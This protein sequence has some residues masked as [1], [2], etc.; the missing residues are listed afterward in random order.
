MQNWVAVASANHVAIG[1]AQGF[2]QVNH[3][4]SGPLRRMQPK[5]VIAYYSPTLVYGERTPLQAFT[6]LG[7][8]AEGAPY[9]GQMPGGF[10]PYRRDVIWLPSHPA[11]IAPLLQQLECTAGKSNWGYPF[12][13]GLFKIT[14]ADMAL[15]AHAMG[16]VLPPQP[17]L[18]T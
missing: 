15:I 14:P 17:P 16:C 1:R 8:I 6:A 18:A 10:T 11:P 12:R 5:D 9:V 13:F 4:K 2:A 7:Q 3:G